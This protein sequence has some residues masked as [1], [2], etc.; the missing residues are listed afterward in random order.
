MKQFFLIMEPSGADLA[1]VTKLIEAGKCRPIVDS[2]WPLE[3]FQYGYQR[4]ERGQTRGKVIFDLTMNTPKVDV[5][6]LCTMY[7]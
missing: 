2:V 1:E 5:Q 4:L 6:E 3:R 7:R